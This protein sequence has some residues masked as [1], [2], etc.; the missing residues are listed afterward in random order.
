MSGVFA[1]NFCFFKGLQSIHASRASLIV[2]TNP[3]F[4]SLLASL[5]FKEK[6]KW[7]NGVGVVLSVFG[8]MVVISRGDVQE[9]V[10]GNIGPGELFIFGCVASWVAYSL[11]G[12]VVMKDLSPLIAVSYSAVIGTVLLFWP[13]YSEG[14]LS[15]VVDYSTVDW[16]SLCYLGW[17]GTVLGFLWYYQGIQAIGPARASQFI[18]FVPVS[19][20]VLAFLLLGEPVTRSLITGAGLVLGGLYLTNATRAGQR[21]SSQKGIY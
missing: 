1:Y 18:N 19:A 20:I 2:A 3:I 17:F 6:M 21:G 15:K 9:I 4:I 10:R 13:A 14:L 5:S 12:K 16:L 8:A 7:L 11:I